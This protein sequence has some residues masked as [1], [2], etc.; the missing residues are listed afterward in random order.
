MYPHT[1]HHTGVCTREP[2]FFIITEFMSEGNLLD[3]LRRCD[4]D[5]LDLVT[6]IH[7]AAQVSTAME[8]LESKKFI[9]R[10][11]QLRPLLLS[12][13]LHVWNPFLFDSQIQS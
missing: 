2:P 12:L 1:T 9:H 11:E 3:Y 7:I 6:R 5:V 8:Y 10:L 13:I 4:H